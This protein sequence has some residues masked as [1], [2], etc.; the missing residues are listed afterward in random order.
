MPVVFA[1]KPIIGI[2]GG[3]GSGK[4][5][6]ADVFGSEG[7]LVIRSDDLAKAAYDDP[8]VR[9]EVER[10]I[11]PD[12]YDATGKVRPKVIAARIFADPAAKAALERVLHPWVDRRRSDLISSAAADPQV[13]AYL[14]DTPL[15]FETGLHAQCDAVVFVDAPRAVRSSRVRATRGWDEAELA[16]R[17]NLQWPLDKKRAFAEYAIENSADAGPPPANGDRLRGQ[18][19][20]VLTLILA[21]TSSRP[22]R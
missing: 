22:A 18:V 4:S 14:W 12:A 15:L 9:R 17:E 20:D 16:R 2:A 10:I 11:G 3:I 21:T 19:R 6:V 5:F 13:K 8:A 1:G 7:C